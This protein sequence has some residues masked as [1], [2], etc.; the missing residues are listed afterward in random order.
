MAEIIVVDDDAKLCRMLADA[1]GIEGH[2]VRGAADGAELRGLLAE[3]RPT[4]SSST[5]A[6]RARTGS[7]S[8]AGSGS[9]TTPASSC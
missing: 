4:S 9:T 3:R 2:R 5:S 8:P 1:L 6:C 7:G